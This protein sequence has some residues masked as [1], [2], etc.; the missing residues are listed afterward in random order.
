[1]IDL[2][3]YASHLVQENPRHDNETLFNA[4]DKAFPERL[5][6]EVT[7][8]DIEQAVKEAL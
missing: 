1:M 3:D 5:Y 4:L 2:L 7:Q 8:E 6:L